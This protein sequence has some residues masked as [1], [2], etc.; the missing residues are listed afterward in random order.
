MASASQSAT[1][2]QS[3]LTNNALREDCILPQKQAHK[4]NAE[5]A[6]KRQDKASVESATASPAK[7]VRKQKRTL[8]SQPL[9]NI[10][11]VTIDGNDAVATRQR[12]ITAE[13]D[14]QDGISTVSSLLSDALT[15]VETRVDVTPV[16]SGIVTTV[17]IPALD[18]VP[19]NDT[20]ITASSDVLSSLRDAPTIV[21]SIN[22]TCDV[23][24]TAYALVVAVE[25]VVSTKAKPSGIEQMPLKSTQ[26]LLS[27]ESDVL[28]RCY[29][30]H[31]N[32]TSN[33][34]FPVY[35]T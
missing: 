30:F 1:V 7:R 19:S 21:E 15:F 5:V 34:S 24:A 31:D 18:N 23:V 22:R 35:R 25:E 27:S 13:M 2:V 17:D 11:V 33:T 3:V 26:A 9:K 6:E 14:A 12:T 32:P 4:R 10:D 29:S 8:R 20:S 28:D 16:L